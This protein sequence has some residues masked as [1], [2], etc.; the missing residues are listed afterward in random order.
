M[1]NYIQS[2]LTAVLLLGLAISVSAGGFSGTTKIGWSFID[3]EGSQGVNQPTFN[4]YDG[5]VLSLERFSLSLDNGTRF[6]GDL[7]NITLNN[8]NLKLGVQRPGR[9][10]F[11][12]RN[13]QYR[14]TY[15]HDGGQFTRRRVTDG[16]FW[17]QPID[18][19]RVFGGLGGIDKHGN[20]VDLFEP[21]GL[22]A[23]RPFDYTQTYANA[24]LRFSKNRNTAQLEY[25]QSKFKDQADDQS[26]R[27][28]QTIRL[29]G[30]APL[31]WQSDLLLSAGFQHYK[32]EM[33]NRL[34]T[35]TTNAVWG[36]ARYYWARGYTFMYSF[37]FDRARRTEDI[38]GTDNILHGLYATR[39]WINKGGAT[40][41]YRYRINDNALEEEAT[42]GYFFSGW[43]KPATGFKVKAG[44]GSEQTNVT[45]T[46]TLVGDE[47]VTRYWTQVKYHRD[48]FWLSAKFRN[49][50][51]ENEEIG[52]SADYNL[53]T[54]DLSIKAAE[55]GVITAG[56]SFADGD[57][58]NSGG[59][60]DY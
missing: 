37:L 21:T 46:K 12:L 28:T 13:N 36:A 57:Y 40:A 6:Y 10:D 3:E 48:S 5:P 14:R 35:L 32:A 30:S 19:V 9:Y 54:T 4:F 2:G 26:D 1:R 52:S 24:G 55:F 16:Q 7:R 38:T 23:I 43:I 39:T 58:T 27:N 60:F 8:R 33:V 56:Y 22:S 29:T 44:Y 53:I 17:V 41:G 42:H 34:D 31:P 50:K 59:T 20:S 49:R 15:S 11:R 45:S 51:T 18:A 47:S 25:R